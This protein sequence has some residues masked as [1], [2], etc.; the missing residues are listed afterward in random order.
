M[1]Q[2]SSL[3]V[4][5]STVWAQRLTGVI[6]DHVE[7]FCMAPIDRE[8]GRFLCWGYYES[9]SETLVA[10]RKKYPG[11]DEA[12]YAASVRAPVGDK[13]QAGADA[14]LKKA[15][16]ELDR[17]VWQ[18]QDEPYVRFRN[19]LAEDL[20][21]WRAIKQPT[22]IVERATEADLADM[23]RGTVRA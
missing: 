21:Y 17:T 16:V 5:K 9:T 7:L 11:C 3:P 22:M 10:W 14:A 2:S 4:E 13:T 19:K 18:S 8:T 6:P 1:T 23:L 12:Y 20:A 15:K